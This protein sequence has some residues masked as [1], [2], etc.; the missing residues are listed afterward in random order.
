MTHKTFF[1][2]IYELLHFQR[3]SQ[4]WHMKSFVNII[5]RTVWSKVLF[6]K[7][8]GSYLVNECP[9]FYGKHEFL[10]AARESTFRS[11]YDLEESSL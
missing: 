3:L 11:C 10:S 9:A 2:D 5:K 4:H 8:V 1:S 7:W 6:R